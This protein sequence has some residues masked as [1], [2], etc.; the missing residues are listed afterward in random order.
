MKQT[1]SI[2]TVTGSDSTGGSGVQADTKTIAELGGTAYSAI[3]C[4]TMQNSL[5]IQEFFDMPVPVVE[6]QIE[7][8]VNDAEPQVVKIGLLRSVAMVEAVAGL[9]RRYK[10]RYVVYAPTVR[11]A[12]GDVLLSAEVVEAVNR[13]LVPLCSY[14]VKHQEGGAHG[15]A[16]L[17]ASAICVYLSRGESIESAVVHAHEY[18][19][20]RPST[21]SE[22]QAGRATALYRQFVERVERFFRLYNDVAFYATE[23]NVGSRYLAQVTRRVAG[24][25]PKAIIEERLLT[26]VERQVTQTDQPLKLIAADLGFSSSAHLTRFFK[27]HKGITPSQLRRDKTT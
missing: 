4:V 15:R 8:V 27:Q 19:N 17:F 3:T 1:L 20:C 26:E 23:L 18:Q 24:K 13:C 2:L 11:S 6:A 16:N 21:S 22:Q 25:S 5:G 10:P 12:R 9:L 14:V 7:A